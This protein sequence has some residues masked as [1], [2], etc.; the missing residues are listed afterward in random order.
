M[1]SRPKNTPHQGG[2]QDI[3]YY[4]LVFD[5]RGLIKPIPDLNAPFPLTLPVRRI[6][7]KRRSVSG[8]VPYPWL[9]RN[10]G[11]EST[12]ERDFL[13]ILKEEGPAGIVVIDQPLT[14]NLK[15]LGLGPGRFT[16][17]FLTWTWDARGLGQ[18]TLVEVKPEEILQR[19][20]KKLKPKFLAGIRFA[21]R[22][23]WR[24]RVISDRHL[25]IPPTSDR[26]WPRIHTPM[27]ELR[28][29]ESLLNHLFWRAS[30]A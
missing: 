21:R 10:I 23:G 20:L 11:F 2:R 13:L 5:P 28:S 25:R 19:D 30:H 18:V 1:I 12:L 14:L 17:D 15:P 4:P 8:A 22:Q 6:P 16:P 24:F 26:A 9:G 7:T 3:A 29:T 27:R